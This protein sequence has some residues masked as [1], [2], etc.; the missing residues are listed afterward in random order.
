[1]SAERTDEEMVRKLIE[2][3]RLLIAISEEI[4]VD[5]KLQT[6]P[7]LGQLA[8]LVADPAPDLDRVR[9]THALLERELAAFEDLT[10]LLAAMRTFLPS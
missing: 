10:A 7:L 6:E 9:A 4:P 3:S 5:T 1:M 8:A 2:R